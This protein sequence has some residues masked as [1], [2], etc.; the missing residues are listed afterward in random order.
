MVLRTLPSSQS[1]VTPSSSEM[2]VPALGRPAKTM[3]LG[4][5]P[6]PRN[7]SIM[8]SAAAMID[9]VSVT[10]RAVEITRAP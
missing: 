5:Y 1:G 9:D 7:C 10:S 4:L 2:S 8:R 6:A 3:A